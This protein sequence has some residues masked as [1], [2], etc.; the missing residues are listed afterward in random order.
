MLE[1]ALAPSP[2][3]ADDASRSFH[4]TADQ[5]RERPASMGNGLSG[6][7]VGR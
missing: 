1:V 4:N 5:Q 2:F 3:D 7:G 6:A